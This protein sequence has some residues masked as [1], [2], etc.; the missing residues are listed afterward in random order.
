MLC[1]AANLNEALILKMRSD[2]I[3]RARGRN[4]VPLST[5]IGLMVRERLTGQAPPEAAR[6]GVDLVRQ[7]IEDKAGADLDSLGLALDDQQTFQKLS[8]ALLEHLDLVDAD[9]PPEQSDEDG[10]Q[11]E[12]EEGE[13]EQEGDEDQDSKGEAISPSTRASSRIKAT[14]KTA[15]L[16]IVR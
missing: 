3:S 9:A 4:E 11:D 14:A 15:T 6:A 10:S 12:N 1:V 13:D 16:N 7:W 8:A 2:P 5:A